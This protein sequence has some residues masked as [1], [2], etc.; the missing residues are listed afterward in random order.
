M[1]R[2]HRREAEQHRAPLAPPRPT[3]RRSWRVWASVSLVLAFALCG[4]GV[5][6]DWWT[7]LPDDARATYVG[8]ASCIE[9][10]AT[11]VQ[12]WTGSDH[13]RAM[14][15]ATDETVL[16]DFNDVEFTHHGLTSRMYRSGSRF[17]ICTEGPHGEMTDFEV[18]YVL[19]VRP[20]Q[21]YMVEFDRPKDMPES[22]IARLQVLR[23]SWDTERKEWFY[24]PPP[25]VP[26]RLA[27]DDMLHWTGI[28][29]CWNNMCA[30][31]HSTNLQ[32]AFDV[33]TLTYRTTYA[34]IDV[35][36]EAC[37][38]PASLHVQLARSR[39]LFWDRRRGYGL[40]QLKTAETRP[41]IE[42]C[43]PCHS[44]RSVQAPDFQAGD[45]YYDYFNNELLAEETYYADG[46]IMDEDYVFGSFIQSRMFHKNIRCTDCHNPHTL[47]LKQEGNR[48]CTSCH[49]H[50]AAKYDTPRHHFHKAD[51]SGALC[52][53]C[54]MPETTY[55][56]V[57]P[58]RDHSIRNPRPDLSVRW[59]IPNACT[60][61]H[62][63]DARL[64]D[65]KR[66]SLPQY[67]DWI[68]AARAGDE[69]VRAELARL[70]QWMLESMQKWYRKE[71]WGDHFAVA[72]E[73]GRRNEPGAELLLA[74]VAQDRRIP[75]IARA[76]ALAQRGL[77]P[78]L[79][80]FEPELK[81]LQDE[82][83]Q[84]RTAAVNRFVDQIPTWSGQYMSRAERDRLVEGLQPVVKSLLPLLD[85][86]RR[87]VRAAAGRVLARLPAPLV[88]TMLNGAQ[89]KQLDAAIDQYVTGVLEMNDR[90]GAHLE[91][92]VLY[93]GLGD[94]GKAEA[95]YRTAIRVE[96]QVAGPRSNLAALLERR[97]SRKRELPLS[98]QTQQWQ[99]EVTRLRREE[100]DLLA[101]DVQLLPLS[102]ALQY[103]YGLSL[104]LHKQPGAA[105]AALQKACELD[106]ENGH[107]LYTLAVFYKDS[108]RYG[109]ALD[110]LD[111]L[112][113]LRPDDP[114][115]R[116]LRDEVSQQRPRA[117]PP[118]TETLE[119]REQGAGDDSAKSD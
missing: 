118:P 89:R 83:P 31:C 68:A 30:Y 67:R 14:D 39:S 58:R 119:T 86:P 79:S 54:H 44:R 40:T 113:L 33:E 21:N 95:A 27:P 93:E 13:D 104:Y 59:G 50:P 114:E 72:L 112:L 71:T 87:V 41:Q 60:R 102:A 32:K 18:K 117:G 24:L 100:L 37:H 17:M 70:D 23:I 45:Q 109:E 5:L 85:D 16:G 75:A 108:Q 3:A 99:T 81:G 115:Y 56:E 47:R 98:S 101:R 4:C 80:S 9:C 94:E 55:M 110:C 66:R 38:G 12:Q 35:S 65:E 92:G 7:C 8:R 63:S 97:V 106:P 78:S 48:V 74:Q 111:R 15:V 105:E 49:Q 29:Q 1:G 2:K 116:Q 76:T 6:A 88:G 96:P 51:G 25:D 19:G 28:G 42:T 90:G 43:A 22:E 20:L 26:E 52:V 62:L 103:R 34:E 36:C 69:E 64:A 91:L 53:E 10:H 73:A 46:Q 84:V 77:L 61:C 11:E 82:D 57:D 107:F